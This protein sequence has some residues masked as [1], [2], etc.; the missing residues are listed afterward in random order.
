MVSVVVAMAVVKCDGVGVGSGK[1]W[2]AV[3]VV[4]VAVN[5]AGDVWPNWM[6]ECRKDP[7]ALWPCAAGP[8]SRMVSVV[9]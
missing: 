9:R 6:K 4:L 5:V 7:R 1:A 8:A 2:L 3:V